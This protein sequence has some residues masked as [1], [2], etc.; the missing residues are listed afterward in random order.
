[1]SGVQAS[2]NPVLQQQ[3]PDQAPGNSSQQEQSDDVERE[4]NVAILNSISQEAFDQVVA[5]AVSTHPAF[6]FSSIQE[7]SPSYLNQIGKYHVPDRM[8][9][10]K[11]LE[12]E[13]AMRESLPW[14]APLSM[15]L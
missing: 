12:K 10:R 13:R 5:A 2:A 3:A 6:F 1:M 9:L 14:G 4:R 15:S 11:R 8:E 7:T